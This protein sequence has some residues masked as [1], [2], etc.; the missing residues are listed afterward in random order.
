MDAFLQK[1][2][3][4]VVS[5]LSGFDRLVFRGTLRMLAY[6]AGLMKYL[7]AVQVLLK[8]FG[9]HAE[10]LTRRLR[11]GSETL[12][13]QTGRPI[14]YL[15]SSATNKELVAREIAAADHI[16]QGLICILEVVEP[17][18]S[19][20]IVRDRMTK[21]LLLA[22]RHRKCLHLYHYQFHPLFGF[23]HAR[24]QTWLPFSVQICLNG[25][26]WLARSM[27]LAGLHYIQRGNCFTWLEQPAQA[28]RLL[29]Q[30][31]QAAW[32]ELL[33]GLARS[34]NPE[35]APMFQ[36]FPVEYYWST[37][38]SEWATDVLFRDARTLDRL[39]PKLVRHGLTTFF[40]TDVMR[41]LGRNIPASGNLPPNLQAEVVSDVKVRPEGVRIK[42]RLGDNSVKA[43][44][45]GKVPHPD[46]REGAALR[47]E[48]TI[49]DAAGFKT[50]R[51]PEGKP[52]APAA[53]AK[54]KPEGAKPE[55]AKP[56]AA[57]PEAAKPEGEKP[58]E[59]RARHAPAKKAPAEHPE[60]APAEHPAVHHA[61]PHPAPAG[62][63]KAAPEHP[64]PAPHPA[65]AAKPAEP[66]PAEPDKHE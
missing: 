47:V 9:A 33:D 7:W 32:P 5:T 42:H 41:F 29:D 39:Y 30:Q 18:V 31:V 21:R 35:H 60:G 65:P 24:I 3:G 61:A 2:A 12:A 48:T 8:D 37:H 56:E 36:A 11:Q 46:P 15:A 28:Q 43:Y 26:E 25:R 10:A 66:K 57:K 50:F 59:A 64:R 23:M 49:N 1:H 45:K 51:R 14:V 40:S 13:R 22:P 44:D 17:C 38:Q 63:P 16:E 55:A 52:E 54:E 34:L 53:M 20:E 62:E 19:Y 58:A 4:S 27:D 6:P